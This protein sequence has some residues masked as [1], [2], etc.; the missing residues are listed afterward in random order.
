MTIRNLPFNY[1]QNSEIT[2]IPPI[3]QALWYESRREPWL[4]YDIRDERV[5]YQLWPSPTPSK[6]R[7]DPEWEPTT[8]F[9]FDMQTHEFGL[10]QTWKCVESET[11]DVV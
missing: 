9:Y 2:G 5:W 1:E 11:S 6:I 7:V 4:T 8:H 3:G 10:N